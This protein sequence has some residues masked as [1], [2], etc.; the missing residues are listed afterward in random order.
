VGETFEDVVL[1]AGFL[2]RLCMRVNVLLFGPLSRV[3]SSDRVYVE[4]AGETTT[5]GEVLQALASQAAF[6]GGLGG[7][8][9]AVNH[10]FATIDTPIGE[11]DEVALIGMVSGG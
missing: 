9:L 2:R 4:V 5:A 1:E 3:V 6:P 7:Y 8:H 10:A 11:R